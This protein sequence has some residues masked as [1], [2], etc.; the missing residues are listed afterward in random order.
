MHLE[1]LRLNSI[2]AKLTMAAGA[3]YILS[4]AAF[5]LFTF[6]VNAMIENYDFV[7]IVDMAELM[8][9]AERLNTFAQLGL[10][11]VFLV[12]FSRAYHNL[13][14]LGK[15][16]NYE[17]GWSV[18]AWFV[19]VLSWFRPWQLYSEMVET[20]SIMAGAF[21]KHHH[22]APPSRRQLLGLGG[23]W[24]G[25]YIGAG[26]LSVIPVLMVRADR[27]FTVMVVG[28][29]LLMMVP[30]VLMILVVW[31]TSLIEATMQRIWASGDYQ[32]YVQ[33]REAARDGK[34]AATEGD[35]P[36][37]WYKTEA[38]NEKQLNRNEDPFQ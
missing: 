38:E 15:V 16:L 32:A 1:P 23:W 4:N 25:T 2:P 22:P 33:E 24:W 11:I 37:E 9:G 31:R 3:L 8:D 27:E 35:K 21:P 28:Q 10:A 7:G 26:F 20:Y 12:W 13:R 30:C 36:A 19:P 5:I 29:P 6:Q 14:R 18:G 17:V 34:A